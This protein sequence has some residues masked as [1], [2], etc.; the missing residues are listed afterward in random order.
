MLHAKALAVVVA[1]DIYLECA[2]G[3]LRAGEWKIDNPVSFHR[4]REKLASQMI[5]YDPQQRKY[6]G[7]EKFRMSTQQ[8]KRR[9]LSMSFSS[10]TVLAKSSN[11]YCSG[12]KREDF[13]R[14]HQTGS[15]L[16][17]NLTLL[18]NHIDS[19]K[20]IPNGGG[21][22]CVVCGEKCYFLCTE[23]VGPDGKQ[24]VAM[25]RNVKKDGINAGCKISCF[26]HHH[27]TAFFGLAKNDHKLIGILRKKDWQFPSEATMASHRREVQNIL[28]PVSSIP[29]ASSTPTTGSDKSTSIN[30]VATTYVYDANGIRFDKATGQEVGLL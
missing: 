21:K 3:V 23:C 11:E 17:G 27:N 26:Y 12:L 2:A 24:G 10:A 18:Y 7:D 25:H 5:E 1:Y 9:R 28:Q 15:R 13:R 20:P 14:T 30:T 4:F 8:H 6:P 16:C 29:G 19:V 22:I